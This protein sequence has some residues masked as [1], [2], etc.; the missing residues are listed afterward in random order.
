VVLES[1]ASR[2]WLVGTLVGCAIVLAAFATLA[3]VYFDKPRFGFLVG[4]YFLELISATIVLGA[5]VMLVSAWKATP[6]R[7]WA[8]TVLLLWALIALA[9]PATGWYFL[10]PAFVLVLSLPVMLQA[11]HRLW[12]V[13]L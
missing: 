2:R 8:K 11:V 6:R 13:S 10:L 12:R 9:S 3:L 5:L 7:D 1:H 4:R